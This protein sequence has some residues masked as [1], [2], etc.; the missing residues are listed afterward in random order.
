MLKDKNIL[1]KTAPQKFPNSPLAPHAVTS[2]RRNAQKLI[3]KTTFQFQSE[4]ASF[5]SL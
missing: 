1:E 3:D 2:A 5:C 4:T